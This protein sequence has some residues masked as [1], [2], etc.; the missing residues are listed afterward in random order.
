MDLSIPDVV[1]FEELSIAL[2][3]AI[4]SKS[5]WFVGLDSGLSH[6]ASSFNIPVI[7]LYPYLDQDIMPFEVRVH[8]P[9]S[10]SVPQISTFL[11]ERP[12]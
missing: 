10:R 5:A 6:V 4:I 12:G 7:V 9:S 11:T 2:S 3:G 1:R 8:T